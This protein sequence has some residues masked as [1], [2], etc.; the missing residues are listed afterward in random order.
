MELGKGR[1]TL[2]RD[3][4]RALAR[5]ARLILLAFAVLDGVA[6]EVDATMPCHIHERVHKLVKLV[7]EPEIPLAA[8]VDRTQPPLAA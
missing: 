2:R 4:T 7:A 8:K 5:L 1:E 3:Q 6:G